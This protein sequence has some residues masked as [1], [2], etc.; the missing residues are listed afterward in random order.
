MQAYV[1]PP[2][3]GATIDPTLEAIKRAV[4][5]GKDIDIVTNSPATVD[6]TQI[7][8]AIVKYGAQ[9][10]T[11][12]NKIRPNALH[13]F[14]KK[15]WNGDGG[16]T[17]HAKVAYDDSWYVSDTSNNLHANGFVQH[18]SQRYYL[19]DDL[20]AVVRAWGEQIKDPQYSTDYTDPQLLIQEQ[21]P[22]QGATA[23]ALNAI[24]ALFPYQL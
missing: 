18:E 6:T 17:L 14:M 2:I 24:L 20:N 3:P 4:K 1:L 10:L 7:S 19:D 12:A 9:L 16:A 22:K 5:E 23:P 21:L 15:K 8:T 13:I 11:E